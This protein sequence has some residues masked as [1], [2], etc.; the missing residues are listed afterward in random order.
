VNHR[1]VLRLNRHPISLLPMIVVLSSRGT[2]T[3]NI[4]AP[5]VGL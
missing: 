2:S 5:S 1:G 4:L 3:Q